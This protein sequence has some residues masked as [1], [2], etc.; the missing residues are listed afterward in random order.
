MRALDIAARWIGLVLF[1][2]TG[3]LYLVSGLV[4]PMWAVIVLWVV[5]LAL[6]VGIIKLWRSHPWLV[7]AAPLVAFL[8]W[9]G[10][11]SAGGYF[12]DWTA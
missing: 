6:L 9:A 7:L 1:I 11:I 2:V 10:A 4:A 3:W 8:I 5:W 12:L